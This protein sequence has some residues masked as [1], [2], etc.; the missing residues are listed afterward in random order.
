MNNLK[1]F[2][3]SAGFR[4]IDVAKKLKIGR[5][6]Y[7]EYENGKIIPPY[8]SLVKLTE[9]FNCTIPDLMGEPVAE[10]SPADLQLKLSQLDDNERKQA[11][12]YIEF[13]INNK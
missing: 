7:T 8:P 12:K 13:L 10:L 2:R 1:A 9:L 3:I 11:I 4:Q 6:T 5:T